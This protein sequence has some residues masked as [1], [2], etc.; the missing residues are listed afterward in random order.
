M[1]SDIPA[2]RHPNIFNSWM[3]SM[4]DSQNAQPLT[5]VTGHEPSHATQ[6]SKSIFRKP[7][8]FPGL[9]PLPSN[10]APDGSSINGLGGGGRGT[11]GLEP[12]SGAPFRTL[13]PSFSDSSVSFSSDAYNESSY[14]SY[15]NSTALIPTGSGSS[16]TNGLGDFVG[17]F[18]IFIE[19]LKEKKHIFIQYFVIGCLIGIILSLISWVFHLKRKRQN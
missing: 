7:R 5:E 1:A 13:Q 15:P 17:S 18:M 6:V 9:P 8:R 14:N 16:D 3:D 2:L 12:V 10:R 4:M 19:F 11:G